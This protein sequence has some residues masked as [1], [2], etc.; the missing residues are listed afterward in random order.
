M[1]NLIYDTAIT[2]NLVVAVYFFIILCFGNGYR[3]HAFILAVSSIIAMCMPISD[4]FKETNTM[5]LL[6]GITAFILTMFLVFDKLAWKQA[7]V[8]AFATLCHVMIIYD[9]TITSSWFSLFFYN[10]YDELIIAVGLTQMAVSYD[11]INTALRNIRELVSWVRFNSWCYTKSLRTSQD[12]R[13][14]T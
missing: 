3:I 8:L 5:I 14:R 13:G 9:L 1:S 7:L 12:K 6:D 11:G 10:Y 4:F 2:V